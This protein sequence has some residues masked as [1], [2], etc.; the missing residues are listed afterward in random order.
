MCEQHQR[1]HRQPQ[2]L[3]LDNGTQRRRALVDIRTVLLEARVRVGAGE[4]DELA[5]RASREQDARFFEQLARRGHV[6]RACFISGHRGQ[7]PLRVLETVAPRRVRVMVRRVHASARKHVSA[8]HER[9]AM[10]L[11]VAH[12]ARIIPYVDRVLNLEDGSLRDPD[13]E[14]SGTNLGQHN[15]SAK[16]IEAGHRYPG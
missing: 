11:I 1:I 13:E 15:G 2:R 14:P 6:I 10:V 7:L 9:G 12:D 3:A 16:S 4:R 8:A 5:V